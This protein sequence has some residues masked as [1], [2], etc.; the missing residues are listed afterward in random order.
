M[1]GPIDI[2]PHLQ[3]MSPKMQSLT[4]TNVDM[5]IDAV[6]QNVKHS[7]I[8]NDQAVGTPE[9]VEGQEFSLRHPS[10]NAV[11]ET[12]RERE[13]LQQ[14]SDLA[15]VLNFEEQVVHRC[16]E[17]QMDVG[18]KVRNL[19]KY[20]NDKFHRVATDNEE[21]ARQLTEKE[22]AEARADV[23]RQAIT[24]IEDRERRIQEDSNR[25]VQ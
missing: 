16:T 22:V 8:S 20:Q 2:S 19:L 1:S 21:H 6:D 7:G 25:L 10:E 11:P 13:L 17:V 14:V 3:V 15:E 24:A 4:E 9:P 18:N 12:T 23:H 5:Q